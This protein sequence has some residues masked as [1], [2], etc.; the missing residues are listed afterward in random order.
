MS[1]ITSVMTFRVKRFV[2]KKCVRRESLVL[3][4]TRGYFTGL[5]YG[6][7][8]RM[9]TQDPYYVWELR[10]MDSDGDFVKVH[11]EDESKLLDQ[12]HFARVCLR[13][14]NMT[15]YIVK[16]N[17]WFETLNANMSKVIEVEVSETTDTSASAEVKSAFFRYL[18]QKKS[19][20]EVS[21]SG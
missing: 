7:I 16:E 13:H 5:D 11:F 10:P 1:T 21:R 15:P 6:Q 3:V 20:R 19:T 4:G 18:A 12:R 14:L 9:M 17:T 2:I 8:Y